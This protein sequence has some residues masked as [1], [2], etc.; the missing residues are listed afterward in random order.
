MEINDL[1]MNFDSENQ[2][3]ESGPNLNA[4]EWW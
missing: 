1:D 3:E 4:I 2:D